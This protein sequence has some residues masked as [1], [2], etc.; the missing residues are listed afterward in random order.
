MNSSAPTIL[1]PRVRVPNTPSTLL[2]FAVF[3]LYLS[4][5][6]NKKTKRGRVWSIIKRRKQW[7]EL[8]LKE[9]NEWM[10]VF[11][12]NENRYCSKIVSTYCSIQVSCKLQNSNHSIQFRDPGTNRTSSKILIV[13]KALSCGVDVIILFKNSIA[14][15]LEL[16]WAQEVIRKGLWNVQL[17]EFISACLNYTRTGIFGTMVSGWL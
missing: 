15:L 10:T 17:E 13:G 2:S 5:E 7:L 8:E 16:V 1:L 6:K 11:V 4:C 14:T 3:V 12:K 9:M